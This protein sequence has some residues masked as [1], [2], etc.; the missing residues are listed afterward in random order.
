MLNGVFPE[1]EKDWTI[2][3]ISPHRLYFS[4]TSDKSSSWWH[5][6]SILHNKSKNKITR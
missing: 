2:F 1:R 5:L 4:W 6:I 3:F